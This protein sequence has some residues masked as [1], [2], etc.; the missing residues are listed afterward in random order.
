MKA[1][2]LAAVAGVAAAKTY[3]KETFDTDP[4]AKRWTV[5]SE[6]KSA[7]E[8]STAACVVAARKV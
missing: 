2:A 4:L 8:V 5:G 1:T 3:L 7:A 6:W